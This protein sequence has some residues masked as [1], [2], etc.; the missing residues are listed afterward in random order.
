M[1][2]NY[3][4]CFRYILKHASAD[5]EKMILGNKCDKNDTR[6]VS[7]ERGEQVRLISWDLKITSL[8]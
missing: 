2:R 3:I 7:K 4:N 6:Q 1:V 8:N 5:V